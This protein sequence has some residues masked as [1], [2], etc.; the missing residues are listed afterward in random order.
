MKRAATV[1]LTALAPISWGSTY[2]VATELLPPTGRCS[3]GSCGPCPPDS[4]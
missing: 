3:P 2:A 1:A 4:C